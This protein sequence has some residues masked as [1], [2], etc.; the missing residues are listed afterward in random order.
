MVFFEIEFLW[1]KTSGDINIADPPGS[2]NKWFSN[3]AF[4]LL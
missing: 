1:Q 2:V 3:L 4:D